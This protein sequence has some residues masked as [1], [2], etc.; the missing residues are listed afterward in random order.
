MD[1]KK[2]KFAKEFCFHAILEDAGKR[3]RQGLLDYQIL[4][5]DLLIK[6]PDDGF[7]RVGIAAEKARVLEEL[8]TTYNRAL[9]RADKAEGDYIYI[10]LLE[11]SG[12]NVYDDENPM[13]IIVDQAID[14]DLRV[15]NIDPEKAVNEIRKQLIVEENGRYAFAYSTNNKAKKL[16]MIGDRYSFAITRTHQQYLHITQ[17]R[18]RSNRDRIDFPVM[19]LS[20]VIEISDELT[21]RALLTAKS[22]EQYNKLVRS[23]TKFIDLWNMNE[24]R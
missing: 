14:A 12:M 21:D 17:I 24:T 1:S 5:D 15:N 16:E 19:L 9:L 11:F 10:T 7:V 23:D 22:D 13:R 8:H 6:L 2:I 18:K 20:G 3:I 4:Q